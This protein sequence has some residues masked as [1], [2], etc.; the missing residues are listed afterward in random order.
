MQHPHSTTKLWA[1]TIMFSWLKNAQN[2]EPSWVHWFAPLLNHH[3]RTPCPHHL[4]RQPKK[5]L[6]GCLSK[7]LSTPLP[8][9]S[10][11]KTLNPKIAFSLELYTTGEG[12]AKRPIGWHNVREQF[13]FSISSDDLKRQRLA[14]KIG[15]GLPISSPISWHCHPISSWAF[16]VHRL[17]R[18]S[19]C[20]ISN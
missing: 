10:K 14:I 19:P 16:D 17:N 6:A 3:P 1:S 15:I 8:I 11:P 2:W 18:S 4:N 9:D 7:I 5:E 20:H 13:D 12:L